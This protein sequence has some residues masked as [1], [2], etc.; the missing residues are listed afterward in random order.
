MCE[1]GPLKGDN[2]LRE[3]GGEETRGWM[4]LDNPETIREGAEMS[5]DDHSSGWQGD[6]EEWSG[7]I[8]EDGMPGDENR[9]EQVKLKQT[10][11]PE[12]ID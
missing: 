4:G 3:A 1:T 10:H 12:E 5:G 2:L 9:V 6:D 7:E 8:Q 11:I